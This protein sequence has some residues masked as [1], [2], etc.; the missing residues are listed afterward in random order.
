[1]PLG[2]YLVTYLGDT[3]QGGAT[4]YDLNFK[5]INPETQKIEQEFNVHPYLLMDTKMQ[6]LAPNP[7]T[8]HFLTYDVFT[9]VTSLPGEGSK[10][11][12]PKII[13]D[14]LGMGDT[15]HFN[16]GYFILNDVVRYS[17]SADTLGVKAKLNARIGVAEEVVEPQ[18]VLSMNDGKVMQGTAVATIGNVSVTFAGIIPE[19]NKFVFNVSDATLNTDWI[20]I[21][22]IIFPM[23]NLVWIG[24][25][26]MAIGF[27]ISMR[28]RLQDNRLK[29]Q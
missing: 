8:K 26:V 14:T 17:A 27:F 11:A 2:D 25:I 24:T 28:K 16:T 4:Y 6:Q 29:A 15:L 3:M 19:E 20:V 5:K 9:H 18:F 12:P 13:T 7:D 21:K 22:S 1:M 23:I 10:N